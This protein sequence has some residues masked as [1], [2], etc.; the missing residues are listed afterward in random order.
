MFILQAK[1]KKKNAYPIQILIP[2]L[3]TM[4]AILSKPYERLIE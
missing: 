1:K 2:K 4:L 3:D